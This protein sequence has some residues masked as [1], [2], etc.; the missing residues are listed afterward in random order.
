M[1]K[2]GILIPYKTTRNHEIALLRDGILTVT[3]IFDVEHSD[4][5][6]E[7]WK[8]RGLGVFILYASAVCLKGLIRILRKINLNLKQLLNI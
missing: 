5:R 2:N 7:T 8:L 4:A 3:Q 6:W 1:Q